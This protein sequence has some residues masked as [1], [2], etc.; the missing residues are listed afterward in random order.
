MRESTAVIN[1]DLVLRKKD[2]EKIL[3]NYRTIFYH[4]VQDLKREIRNLLKELIS[5][6]PM[7]SDIMHVKSCRFFGGNASTSFDISIY[8]TSYIFDWKKD[9]EKIPKLYNQQEKRFIWGEEYEIPPNIIR[10]LRIIFPEALEHLSVFKIELDPPLPIE[11]AWTGASVID[12]WEYQEKL[13]EILNTGKKDLLDELK[14]KIMEYLREE[15]MTPVNILIGENQLIN[16]TEKEL[17]FENPILYKLTEEFKLTEDY[18]N[19]CKIR[20]I[21]RSTTS[22]RLSP[23]QVE[24]AVNNLKNIIDVEP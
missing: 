22:D 9:K 16:L 21:K 7:F 10:D 17:A 4:E 13:K 14:E 5:S 15:I 19:Y 2:I 11:I 12:F 1:P 3:S 24:D 6:S 20:G 23:K 8:F 18:S